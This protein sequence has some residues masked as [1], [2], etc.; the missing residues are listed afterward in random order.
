[1]TVAPG[2]TSHFPPCRVG[3]AVRPMVANCSPRFCFLVAFLACVETV[4]VFIP[5][6][7][8]MIHDQAIV[9]FFLPVTC[10]FS[11]RGALTKGGL[12]FTFAF[13]S[14][15]V[16]GTGTVDDDI[17]STRSGTNGSLRATG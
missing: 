13:L 11:S 10:I 17:G 14:W 6:H 1:M 12:R 15:S 9:S 8:T 5:P 7:D 2:H 3:F 16:S 4:C